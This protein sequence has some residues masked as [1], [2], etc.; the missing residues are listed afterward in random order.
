MQIALELH[1]WQR[2]KTGDVQPISLVTKILFKTQ[3]NFAN[4]W[5]DIDIVLEGAKEKKKKDNPLG[6]AASKQQVFSISFS[7]KRFRGREHLGCLCYMLHEGLHF[8]LY[9]NDKYPHGSKRFPNITLPSMH[10]TSFWNNEVDFTDLMT[11][12]VA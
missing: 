5:K 8:V 9:Y 2:D 1:N 7:R 12:L 4:Q 10:H 11:D 6:P 3:R